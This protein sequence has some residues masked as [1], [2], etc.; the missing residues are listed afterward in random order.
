MFLVLFLLLTLSGICLALFMGARTLWRRW[1]RRRPR[2]R[3]DRRADR[4]RHVRERDAYLD[5]LRFPSFYQLVIIFT[6]ASIGGLLLETAWTQLVL[7][8]W[9]RRYGMV[10]GPFSPL[11]GFGAVLLTV[12]LW[13]LRRRPMWVV[14]LFSMVVGSLLEQI[15]G[16]IIEKVMHATSWTYETYPD[17]ITR[18]VALRMSM[19][20]GLLGCAWCRVLMPEALFLIGEPKRRAELVLVAVLTAFLVL[21]GVMTVAVV[22]RKDARD[23]GLPAANAVERVIDRRYDDEFI[24]ER[25]ENVEFD[26]GGIPT[27]HGSADMDGMRAGSSSADVAASSKSEGY[28]QPVSK[29]WLQAILAP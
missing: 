25:F 8:I 18:Y 14:F 2:T 26:Q 13:K 4:E 11:Y 27:A 3:E 10:W 17:A 24:R 16:E 9:Q 23:R 29:N 28:G 15:S 20:W 5:T 6:V 19:I 12:A 7:G 1:R 22:L 21:D